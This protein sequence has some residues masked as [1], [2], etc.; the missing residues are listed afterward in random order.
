MARPSILE[1]EAAI[2]AAMG[3]IVKFR[4]IGESAEGHLVATIIYAILAAIGLLGWTAYTWLQSGRWEPLRSEHLGLMFDQDW[5]AQP[6]TWVGVHSVV[7]WLMDLPAYQS[8]PIA[9]VLIVAIYYKV[10]SNWANERIAAIRKQHKNNP[11]LMS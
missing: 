6:T 3:R 7:T 5:L 9:A 4:N 8:Y 2:E 11:R 10:V 1:Q